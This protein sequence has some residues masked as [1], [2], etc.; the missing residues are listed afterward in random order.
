MLG[1]LMG[2]ETHDDDSPKRAIGVPIAAM[3]ESMATAGLAG[4]RRQWCH[5]AEVRE[6]TL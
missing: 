6:G 4:G 2:D 1:R 3:V 5:A